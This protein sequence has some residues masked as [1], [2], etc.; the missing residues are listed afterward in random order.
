[1]L[2]VSKKYYIFSYMFHVLAKNNMTCSRPT[3]LHC[4]IFA[5]YNLR[6]FCLHLWNLYIYSSPSPLG[7]L[8]DWCQITTNQ[9]RPSLRLNPLKT[10]P[11]PPNQTASR[12]GGPYR[13][14]THNQPQHGYTITYN[15]YNI[16]MYPMNFHEFPKCWVHRFP[17]RS[18]VWSE[19][20]IFT[21]QSVKK[22]GHGGTLLSRFP[23]GS[24]RVQSC[25]A[26]SASDDQNWTMTHHKLWIIS[27]CHVVTV[28]WSALV[29]QLSGIESP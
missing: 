22:P 4:C 9:Q 8:D 23:A 16:S 19:W 21:T 26:S 2:F 7:P 3:I 18:G 5:S 10:H 25:V 27:F 11:D 13:N 1:M 14:L 6:S 15:L 28:A 17:P 12:L 24:R 29:L 20:I